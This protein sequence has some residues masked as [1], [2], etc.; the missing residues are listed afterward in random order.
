MMED[1]RWKWP[2]NWLHTLPILHQ[3]RTPVLCQG[4]DDGVSRFSNSMKTLKFS[5]QR[6]GR[7]Y[8]TLDL[9]CNGT[10]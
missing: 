1:G 2:E 6:V 10:M 3:I 5:I 4:K 9:K 7:I 8:E